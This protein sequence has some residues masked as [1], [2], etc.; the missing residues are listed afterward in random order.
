MTVTPL[1]SSYDAIKDSTGVCASR[2]VEKARKARI[3]I[4]NRFINANIKQ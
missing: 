2:A 4:N 1:W 3:M